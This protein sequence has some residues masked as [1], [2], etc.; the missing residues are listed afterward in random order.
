MVSNWAAP[1]L[2]FAPRL[3]HCT[4]VQYT[5]QA[6][7]RMEWVMSHHILKPD[8]VLSMRF[9]C[10]PGGA[11]AP[12][13]VP[14]DPATHVQNFSKFGDKPALVDGLDGRAIT[15]RDL[16]Y[17][18]GCAAKGMAEKGIADGDVVNIH[19]PNMPVRLSF[20]C[21]TRSPVF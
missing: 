9:V 8:A 18:I 21:R 3:R 4:N 2:L 6:H 13:A 19:M 12:H 17:R 1:R 10:S 7:C 14:C 11:H 16:Y 15:Y 20:P 5:D